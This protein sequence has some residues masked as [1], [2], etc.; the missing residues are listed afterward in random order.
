MARRQVPKNSHGGYNYDASLDC[1]WRPLP[2]GEAHA[3]MACEKYDQLTVGSTVVKKI[4]EP[5]QVVRLRTFT[6]LGDEK[7]HQTIKW[8]D[9]EAGR[10]RTALVVNFVQD[11][12]ATG[13]PWP[14]AAE[15]EV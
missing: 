9:K 15:V 10:D 5:R 7:H 2:G 4:G 13:Q 8:F 6:Y 12:H 11:V 3:V 14:K 1:D